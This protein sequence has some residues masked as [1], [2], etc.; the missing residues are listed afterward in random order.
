MKKFYFKQLLAALLMLCSAIASA[1]DFEAGGIYYKIINATKTVAVTYKGNYYSAYN[2]YSGVVTIPA[3]VTYNGTTYSIT[4]IEKIAFGDCI[5]LTS[6]T[7]PNSVTNIGYSAFSGCDGLTSIVVADGNKVYDSRDNCNAIIETATNTLVY[8][9]QNTVIPN[10]VTSIGICAFE[11]CGGLT[12]IVIPNSVTSIGSIAFAY[13]GNL[14]SIT[15]LIPTENLFAINSNVFN[16]V[17]KT[18]CTLYVPAG[19]KATYEATGGWNEF[20]NIVEIT[21]KKFDLTISAAKYAT[22]YLD[23]DAVIP[24]GLRV[25][26]AEKIE[27]ETL[28]ME[29]I[30]DVIPANTGVIVTG[31]AG[32]YTFEQS[33]D[34]VAAIEKNLFRGSVEDSYIT[35]EKDTKYYVLSMVDGVVGMYLDELAGGTF[36]NNAHKAYLPIFTGESFDIFDTTVNA[37]DVQLS[38]RYTFNFGGITAV[39]VVNAEKQARLSTTST[40][41]A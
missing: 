17:N 10:S 4:S 26:Y 38:N 29:R 37:P 16:N 18:N 36:K 2:E 14:T 22:L 20:T 28:L 8:G 31:N 25:Y 6:I 24:A 19:A 33:L 11:G 39:E 41:C 5:N 7:I 35:P 30:T 40:A 23:Y 32:T 21:P 3:S 1:H 13:C 15:S 12:S 34:N 27:G 9:C